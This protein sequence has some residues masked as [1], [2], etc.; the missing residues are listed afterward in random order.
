MNCASKRLIRKVLS[1]EQSLSVMKDP[2]YYRLN[3]LGIGSYV[4]TNYEILLS[5]KQLFKL[6]KTKKSIKHSVSKYMIDNPTTTSMISEPH[7]AK[8]TGETIHV[9]LGYNWPPEEE[10]IYGIGAGAGA[11]A[12]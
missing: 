1:S 4:I 9:L 12:V 6:F 5:G 3:K 11:G 10:L 2:T 7:C 8:G